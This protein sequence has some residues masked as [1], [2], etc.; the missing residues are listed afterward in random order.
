[1]L[2]DRVVVEGLE[3]HNPLNEGSILWISESR[4]ALGLVDEIFG[5]VKNPYYVVRYNS[6]K[7]LPAGISVGTPVSFVPEFANHILNEKELY[8]KGYDASGEND[9][10][11]NDEVEFSD[12]EKE[13]EY[14]KSLRQAKRGANDRQQHGNR[15][16]ENR[17]PNFKVRG[18]QREKLSTLPHASAPFS[19]PGCSFGTGNSFMSSS[20][21]VPAVP[22]GPVVPTAPIAAQMGNCLINPSQQFLQQQPNAFFPNVFPPQQQQNLGIQ[23]MVANMLQNQHLN[24]NNQQQQHQNQN[25]N[26]LLNGMPCQQQFFPNTGFP[27]NPLIIGGSANPSPT[28]MTVVPMGQGNFGQVPIH[29]SNMQ[30]QGI[31]CFPTDQNYVQPPPTVAGAHTPVQFNLGT[32]LSRGKQPHQRGGRHVFGRGRGPG[33]RSQN[34]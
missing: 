13:A 16:F 1:M 15:K 17:K 9:E 29:C 7:E 34:R 3:K 23:G 6:D 4:K 20:S 31:S 25:L 5:P 10:E 32:S 26:L 33:G 24:I 11:L 28:V 21:M 14:R 19:Q 8:K 30:G 12:D 18:I 2:G 27:T 22:T